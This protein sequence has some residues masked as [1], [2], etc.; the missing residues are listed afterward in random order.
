MRKEEKELTKRIE[1]LNTKE[2]DTRYILKEEYIEYFKEL[3]S[4]L[5]DTITLYNKERNKN[6]QLKKQVKELKSFNEKSIDHINE[7]ERENRYL[8]NEN[9]KL[10]LSNNYY[11]Y[12]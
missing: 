10:N 1:E 2:I 5:N 6:I 3:G 7:L 9:D 4:I 8:N 12:I 11:T